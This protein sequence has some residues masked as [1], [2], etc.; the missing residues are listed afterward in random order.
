M[1]KNYKFKDYDFKLILYLCVITVLGILLVNS[2]QPENTKKQLMGFIAGLAIM[3]ILSFI[4]YHIWLKIWPVYYFLM[5]ALLVAVLVKGNTALG[6]KRW[7][8]LFGIRFQPSEAAKILLILFFAQFIMKFKERINLWYMILIMVI[9][10]IPPLALIFKEPDLSTT[11]VFALIFLSILFLGEI[12]YRYFIA[13]AAVG[14]PAFIIVFLL[15][16]QPDSILVKNSE[17]DKGLVEGYQQLRVL[18]WLHPDE[19]ELEEAFQQQNS[20]MAIGSGQ[21][22]GKGLNNTGVNSVKKGNFISEPQ[23]DFIFTIAGE[24]LGFVGSATI[25]ILLMLITIEC[26]IV[27][28]KAADLPGRIIAGGMGAF[29]GFQSTINI[30]VTTGLFP[31]TGIPLPFV[32]YGLTSLLVIYVGMGF[33]MNVRLQKQRKFNND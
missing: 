29:I 9:L 3:I 14:I 20:I 16:I 8:T 15:L 27:A 31:N 17:N 6:A 32:S 2:A 33:V 19:Y 18:A 24:E 4:D 12:N 26:F 28:F 5:I 30:C 23:T 22:T 13:L 11:I 1:F 25:I 7:F 21:L 10:V